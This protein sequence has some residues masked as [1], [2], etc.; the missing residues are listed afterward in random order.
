M[1]IDG[2]ISAG[3]AIVCGCGAA[4]AAERLG[5]A[6]ECPECGCCKLGVD[7]A[8]D[9][10]LRGNHA[11]RGNHSAPAKTEMTSWTTRSLKATG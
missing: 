11:L 3:Y 2:R 6:V 5:I 10:Y 9:Y 7:I 4:F 8:A 1:R